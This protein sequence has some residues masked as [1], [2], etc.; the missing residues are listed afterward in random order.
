M[1]PSNC[2]HKKRQWYFW[3]CQRQLSK[4]TKKDWECTN[5]SN[6]N[7]TI[8]LQWYMFMV[9]RVLCQFLYEAGAPKSLKKKVKLLEV[10]LQFPHQ[11]LKST[12]FG[13]FFKL[14]SLRSEEKAF[15]KK[16]WP[17]TCR[18]IFV[19]FWLLHYF[20]HFSALRFIILVLNSVIFVYMIL[21]LFIFSM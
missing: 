16:R 13:K 6:C 10:A 3:D 12:Y 19:N 20:F 18:H 21:Y 4:I 8:C 15:F 9:S 5:Y 7:Q 17:C 11:M 2:S 1:K 14:S